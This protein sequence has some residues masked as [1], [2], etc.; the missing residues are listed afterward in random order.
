MARPR[1]ITDEQI[2]RTMRA[3]VLEHGPAVSLDLVAEKLKVTGPALLKRF[4]TRQTLMIEALKPPEEPTWVQAHRE[5]DGRPLEE[6]LEALF[7]D[8]WEFFAE[9]VPCVMA[10]RESGIDSELWQKAVGPGP[11]RG[12]AA[13]AKWLELAKA[14]RLI[15]ADDVETT[16]YTMLGA[17]HMRVITSHITRQSLAT[18]HHRHHLRGLAS[19]F[20]GALAPR[21]RASKPRSLRA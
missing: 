6:Q 16:A 5:V 3:S 9:A 21:R 14:E 4:G 8:I 20:A 11:L 7:T 19:F 10:L 12:L 2:L 13:L 17:L 15:V 18:R 1:L